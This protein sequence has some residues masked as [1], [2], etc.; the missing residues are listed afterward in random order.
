MEVV[1]DVLIASAIWGF[2]I[3]G[4]FLLLGF[5]ASGLAKVLKA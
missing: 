2:F 4:A 3:G 5:A 1:M